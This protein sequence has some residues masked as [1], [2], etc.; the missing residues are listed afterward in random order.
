[1]GRP[2]AALVTGC[3]LALAAVSTAELLYQGMRLYRYGSPA[4]LYPD[5]PML[6]FLRSRAGPFRV[7]G[8]GAVLFPNS[9]IFAGLEDIRTHDPVER[10][11]YVQYL[12]ACCGYP[13]YDYFKFLKNFDSP[14]L[15]RL[16]LKY[17]VSIPGRGTPGPKWKPVYSGSDGTVFENLTALPRVFSRTANPL[18]VSDYRETT[19]SVSFRVN[20]PGPGQNLVV[21]GFVDD[22]GW[23]ARDGERA[24]PVERAE[25]ILTGFRLDPGEHR[26]ELRYRPPGFTAGSAV[27]FLTLMPLLG[28]VVLRRRSRMARAR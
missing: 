8:E 12:D 20:V 26:V 14:V 18:A 11:D 22:G 15:D 4:D 21:A 23:S 27:S 6:S 2:R 1:L 25:E 5:T 28:G 7:L 3:V 13:P 24:L 19:N 10:R 16:N 9:N 17:L